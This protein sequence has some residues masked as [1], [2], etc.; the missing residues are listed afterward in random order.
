MQFCLLACSELGQEDLLCGCNADVPWVLLS[1]TISL[2]AALTLP[3]YRSCIFS[4]S[5]WGILSD[6]CGNGT[7]WWCNWASLCFLLPRYVF[8]LKRDSVL[9]TTILTQGVCA[10]DFT[11]LDLWGSS[12]WHPNP[13]QSGKA[14]SCSPFPLGQV[15]EPCWPCLDRSL[16][17]GR[18]CAERVLQSWRIPAGT[19]DE[20]W[21]L[22]CPQSKVRWENHWVFYQKKEI[23]IADASISLLRGGS[24][25]M[26]YLISKC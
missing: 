16:Q 9:S 25:A 26:L 22:H 19:W 11:E 1:V 21:L 2:R 17:Y 14:P 15:V 8:R 4:Y 10:S 3:V 20:G 23:I 13:G 5:F 24:S 12:W 7:K 6:K 18:G